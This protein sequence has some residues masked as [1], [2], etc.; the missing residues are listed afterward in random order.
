MAGQE[1]SPR[2]GRRN[3]RPTGPWPGDWAGRDGPLLPGMQKEIG[4]GG[5]P[6]GRGAWRDES[7]CAGE[8]G[9]RRGEGG[10]G[11]KNPRGGCSS[12]RGCGRLLAR[13]DPTAPAP[14]PAAT[15]PCGLR[16]AG[17]L[18]GRGATRAGWCA[19]G[20]QR[21]AVARGWAAP[22]R[23]RPRGGG[24]RAAGR[25]GDPAAEVH[26]SGRRRGETALSG[27]GGRSRGGPVQRH[28]PTEAQPI[29]D[30]QGDPGPVSA[31]RDRDPGDGEDG[32]FHSSSQ[33]GLS[34][35]GLFVDHW[36]SHLPSLFVLLLQPQSMSC[37]RYRP[38]DC[39]T[40]VV[41]GGPR[42]WRK[43]PVPRHEHNKLKSISIC[44]KWLQVL[45]A[46]CNNLCI[47]SMIFR[48]VYQY[49]YKSMTSYIL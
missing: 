18:R 49:I 10:D 13:P 29:R 5:P 47:L 8:R 40:F 27:G 19:L 41:G 1:V 21:G 33:N 42:R 28:L 38:R 22:R 43:V 31:P 20:A 30:G 48:Q 16:S 6:K 46:E 37:P 15:A 36:P 34:Q 44:G 14:A 2:G 11:T 45:P 25:E 39:Q 35:N 24:R 3:G 32:G 7:T 23:R 4:S 26:L 9:G 12:Y 17:G